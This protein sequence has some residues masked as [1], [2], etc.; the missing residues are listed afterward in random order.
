MKLEN[1]ADPALPRICIALS[2]PDPDRLLENL[3]KPEIKALLFPDVKKYL[4]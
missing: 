4:N 1:G 3:D 2:F